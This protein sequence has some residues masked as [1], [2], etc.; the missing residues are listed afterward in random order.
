VSGDGLILEVLQVF[1][2]RFLGGEGGR[3]G[4]REGELTSF[5]LAFPRLVSSTPTASSY[6]Y[7]SITFAPSQRQTR[8]SQATSAL[9]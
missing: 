1:I 2:R 9:A 3:E 7:S 8:P 6:E 5:S 4:G